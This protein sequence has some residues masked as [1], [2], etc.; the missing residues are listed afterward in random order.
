MFNVLYNT[1]P[2]YYRKYPQDIKKD[3]KN[4][5]DETVKE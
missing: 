3:K 2:F 1:M 4:E 5:K